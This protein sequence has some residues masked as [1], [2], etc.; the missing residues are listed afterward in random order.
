MGYSNMKVVYMCH[1]GFEIGGLWSGPLLEMRCFQNWPTRKKKGFGAKNDT[2][3]C[4]KR[5]IFS[6]CTGRKSG[7]FR[8]CQCRNGGLSRGTY[9][10]CPNM[11]VWEYPPP[12]PGRNYIPYRNGNIVSI[13]LFSFDRAYR[14]RNCVDCITVCAR[15]D[16][17]LY[18][19]V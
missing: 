7:V 13:V 11:G 16:L 14:S 19:Y 8:S 9:P 4:L 6:S 18:I 3:F 5:R 15:H 2:F 12:P 10:Y 1:G 17:N